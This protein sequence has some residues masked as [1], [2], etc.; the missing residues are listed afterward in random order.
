MKI[1][2]V[3]ATPIRLGDIPLKFGDVL[4]LSESKAESVLAGS[5]FVP[6]RDA[7]GE[8]EKDKPATKSKAKKKAAPEKI[9]T[10]EEES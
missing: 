9:K 1:K 2:Y 7:N 4:D 8:I 10:T 3:G 5:L 6:V